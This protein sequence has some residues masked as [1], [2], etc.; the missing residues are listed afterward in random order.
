[1]DKRHKY[2]LISIFI[3][4]SLISLLDI[5]FLKSGIFGNP[6]DYQNGNYVQGTW[7]LFYKLS[8]A[9]MIL[10]SAAY[11]FYFRSDISETIAIFLG[12]YSLWSYFGISDL[13]FFWYQFRE[14]P[15]SLPWLSHNVALQPV[16]NILG[17][18]TIT[19]TSLYVSA[20]IGIIVIYFTT[21]LL[22][23]KF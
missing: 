11:Y 18:T 20:I 5:A 23:E 21:K 9:I 19:N 7:V 14:V 1:M 12:S 8:L 2:I 13:L 22:K 4:V 15:D 6:I 16:A 10:F 3:V 17:Y